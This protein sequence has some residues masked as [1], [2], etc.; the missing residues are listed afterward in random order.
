MKLAR[1]YK[2]YIN[3][4]CW[5]VE[6][7]SVILAIIRIKTF[8]TSDIH[9]TL[10]SEYYAA[11]AISGCHDGDPVTEVGG[12]GSLGISLAKCFVRCSGPSW[13]TY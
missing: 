12:E 3:H 10:Q 4:L 5:A 8:P 1:Y 9:R 13:I 2:D 6:G 7:I 11:L